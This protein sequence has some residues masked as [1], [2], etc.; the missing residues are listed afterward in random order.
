MSW[1]LKND[2]IQ[3]ILW[4][5]IQQEKIKV[6]FNLKTEIKKAPGRT[7]RKLEGNIKLKLNKYAMGFGF[8]SLGASWDFRAEFLST[9]RL[10]FQLHN[11]QG[12]YF[13]FQFILSS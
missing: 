2:V 3:H 9:C 11:R 4:K 5:C 8:N 7:R 1:I 10:T 6:H 12:I 13:P